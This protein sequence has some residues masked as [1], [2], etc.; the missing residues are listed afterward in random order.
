MK[1]NKKLYIKE[2]LSGWFVGALFAA[3]VGLLI[4]A[5]FI[6][7]K[8]AKIAMKLLNEH[9][10][11]IAE[12]FRKHSEILIKALMA[13][14]LKYKRILDM[15][16][17]VRIKCSLD[18]HEGIDYDEINKKE[19][20]SARLKELFVDAFK[21]SV[22]QKSFVLEGDWDFE[23]FTGEIDD[24]YDLKDCKQDY[25]TNSNR[26]ESFF[27]AIININNLADPLI[28]RAF[29]KI[30]KDIYAIIKDDLTIYG[31]VK[32]TNEKLDQIEEKYLK[33]AGFENYPKGW[34]KG[35]VKKYTTT[36]SNR[37]KG[38]PK[39][40]EWFDKC[41]E[42]MKDKMKNPQGYCA[43]LKDEVYGSTGWRGK[44]KS[45]SEVRKDVKKLR[46]KINK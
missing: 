22:A 31:S 18:F 40:K 39:S 12:I 44:G 32:K 29:N 14:G 30:L 17:D 6:E 25:P 24:E 28:I 8:N 37:M 41:V 2:D 34:T 33:E 45:P 38:G 10:K 42:K 13:L 5:G 3:V 15:Y 20:Y 27:N 1:K 16:R 36:F 43:S 35:S 9:K 7:S 26:V 11:E 4:W 19:A 46:F 21:Q 23:F